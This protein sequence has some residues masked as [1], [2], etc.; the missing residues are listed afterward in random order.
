VIVS[1]RRLQ[2]HTFTPKRGRDGEPSPGWFV[3]YRAGVCDV[4]GAECSQ[5]NAINVELGDDTAGLTITDT[6]PAEL[7]WSEAL[8]RPACWACCMD[9]SR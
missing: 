6:R 5:P 4:C 8:G 1:R 2:Q 3:M 9:A 7:G